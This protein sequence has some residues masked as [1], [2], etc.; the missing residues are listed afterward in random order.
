[1][2]VNWYIVSINSSRSCEFGYFSKNNINYNIICD[3]AAPCYKLNI[4]TAK[5]FNYKK[6]YYYMNK[7]IEIDDNL[8]STLINSKDNIITDMII[9]LIKS[10]I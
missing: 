7:E 4:V 1:M 2:K 8:I 6:R 10:E 3:Q 9:N 5:D